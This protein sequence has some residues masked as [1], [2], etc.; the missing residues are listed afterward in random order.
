MSNAPAIDKVCEFP[1]FLLV[2]EIVLEVWTLTFYREKLSKL[3]NDMTQ[4]YEEMNPTEKKSYDKFI[5]KYRN[6]SLSFGALSMF[7]VYT[8]NIQP[9][10]RV[11]Y[12]EYVN[13]VIIRLYPFHLWF[14]FDNLKYYY[15]TYIYE[16]YV[17]HSNML[18]MAICLQLFILIVVQVS[19][20][21][22]S[23][24]EKLKNIIDAY[25]KKEITEEIL[26]ENIEKIIETHC[27]LIDYSDQISSIFGNMAF[28]MISLGCVI[29]CFTGFAVA[30]S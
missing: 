11:L 26:R 10:G 25:V 27:K 12:A 22:I 6:I 3:L 8:F 28:A 18:V 2:A 23:L 15:T 14:P 29:I 13:D 21:F 19:G 5:W 30:V 1:C 20:L 7:C 24:G 4:I 9:M 17:G 16:V